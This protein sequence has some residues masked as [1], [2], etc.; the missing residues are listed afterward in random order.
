M[1]SKFLP[2]FLIL[3]MVVLNGCVSVYLT[4]RENKELDRYWKE[5]GEK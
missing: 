4:D 2:I 1:R 5:D 3:I